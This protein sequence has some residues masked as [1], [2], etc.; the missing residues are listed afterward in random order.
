MPEGDTL[1]RTAAALRPRLL[2]RAVRRAWPQPLARLTGK[3]VV[4][5]DANGKHLLMRFE[6]GLILH[7]HMR[8]TGSWH[9][10]APGQRWRRPQHLARAVLEFDDVVAVAF[11]APVVELIR[12]EA[13][14]TGHLGPDILAADFDAAVACRLARLSDRVEVGDVLLDQRVCAGIGNIYRCETMWLHQVDP[15]MRVADIGD[16]DLAQLYLTARRL[17]VASATGSAAPRRRAVHARSGRPCRRC[18]QGI[19]TR[20]QGTLARLTYYCPCCQAAR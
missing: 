16:V 10:Y 11:S 7:S 19:R 15:F 17:M 6:G 5:I 18:G 4:G 13:A 12:D 3:R 9:I 14:R 2:E 8:M 20:T 1:W